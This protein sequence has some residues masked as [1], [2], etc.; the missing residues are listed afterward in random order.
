MAIIIVIIWFINMKTDR[1]KIESFI[2]KMKFCDVCIDFFWFISLILVLSTRNPVKRLYHLDFLDIERYGI[3][4][5]F[6]I[7]CYYS[8]FAASFT[9]GRPVIH[10]WY[11]LQYFAWSNQNFICKQAFAKNNNYRKKEWI[12]KTK[13]KTVKQLLSRCFSI[14]RL[15]VCS[16]HSRDCV[17][18]LG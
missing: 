4:F 10:S 6:K 17:S 7:Y 18:W 5:C 14:S 13:H 1:K 2:I 3:V 16:C 9:T 11:V 12:H 15:Y 8:C